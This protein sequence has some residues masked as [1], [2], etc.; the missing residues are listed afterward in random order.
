MRRYD[1]KLTSWDENFGNWQGVRD[2][3]VLLGA[4]IFTCLNWKSCVDWQQ[5]KGVTSA[6]WSQLNSQIFTVVCFSYFPYHGY[7]GDDCRVYHCRLGTRS[8]TRPQQASRVRNAA[9]RPRIT[10][11]WKHVWGT[12]TVFAPLC[13]CSFKI[14]RCKLLINEVWKHLNARHS[15]IFH[16]FCDFLSPMKCVVWAKSRQMTSEVLYFGKGRKHGNLTKVLKSSGI[17]AVVGFGTL[18]LQ[19]GR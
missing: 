16:V 10:V 13:L 3:I 2:G 6:P 14:W 8:S 11:V 19:R 12:V 17:L 5:P 9:W 18:I 15:R 1:R 7:T 4:I